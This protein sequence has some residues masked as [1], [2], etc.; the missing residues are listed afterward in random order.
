MHAFKWTNCSWGIHKHKMHGCSVPQLRCCMFH[1]PH[2]KLPL[3]LSVK[4]AVVGSEPAGCLADLE[5]FAV[6]F[7]AGPM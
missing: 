1:V 5:G 3:T 6:R 7:F 2:A 4:E